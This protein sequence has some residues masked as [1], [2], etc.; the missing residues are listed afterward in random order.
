MSYSFERDATARPA[1]AAI[2]K[3]LLLSSS[4]LLAILAA[5]GAASAQTVTDLEGI[6]IQSANLLDEDY[7]TIAGYGTAGLSVYGS[8][9][10]A[11]PSD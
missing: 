8:I 9:T 11:L 7:E 6:V 4:A 10:M 2:S 3:K 1:R 5:T